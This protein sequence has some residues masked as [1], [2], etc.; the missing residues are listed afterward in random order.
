MEQAVGASDSEGG[1]DW[2]SAYDA[3]E[4]AAVLFLRKFG[5]AM[6]ARAGLAV[7]LLPMLARMARLLPSHTRR[8]VDGMELRRVKVM[9]VHRIELTGFTGAMRERLSAYGLFH[10]IISWKL[11]MFVPTDPHGAEVL[12]KLL[13]RYPLQHIAEREAQ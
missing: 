7:A 2:K 11:R 1:W 3:C 8:S 12:V 6:A 10:E 9:N 4:A 13:G 5:G